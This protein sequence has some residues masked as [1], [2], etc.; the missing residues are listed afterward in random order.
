MLTL[1]AAPASLPP[2]RR[3]YAVGDIHGCADQLRTL[4]A[5]IADDLAAR[6]IENPLLIHIGDYVDRGPD[7]A[8]VVGLLSGGPP[9][10]GLPAI[11]LLGNHEHT[12][13]EALGGERAAG[14]DWLYQGGRAT[15]E[16]YGLDPD[17]PREAWEA[18]PATHRAWMQHLPL[19]HREGGYLFVHAGIRPGIPLEDQSATDLLRIRQPFLYTDQ[20][21]GP[22][23]VHGHTPERRI[24][25]RHNRIGIDTG[26]VFGGHLTCLMLEGDRHA[27]IS[28]PAS[29]A[30]TRG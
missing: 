17:G 28:A 3:I 10:H 23:V 11:N 7:S 20:P 18:V 4:H 25:V 6:P 21:F 15:L 27:V 5:L 16:S 14:T 30:A 1:A 12:M 9:I 13:M 26:A 2:G 22:V 8:G 19:W 24:N 29:N